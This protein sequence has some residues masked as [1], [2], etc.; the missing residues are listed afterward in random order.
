MMVTHHDLIWYKMK[1]ITH[2]TASNTCLIIM[3]DSWA[4]NMPILMA[5]VELNPPAIVDINLRP[6]K[7]SYA[8]H[9]QLTLRACRNVAITLREFIENFA[10]VLKEDVST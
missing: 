1:K 4:I 7:E 10:E 9:Y 2:Y 6:P 8:N 5:Y 3:E